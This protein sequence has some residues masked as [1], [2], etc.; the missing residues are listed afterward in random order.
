MIRFAAFL[1]LAFS[2]CITFA[3]M[4]MEMVPVGNPGND[5]D[6]TGFGRVDYAYNIGKYEVTAGQYTEFLNAVAKIDTYKLYD[7]RMRT[8]A[9]GCKIERSGSLGRYTYSVAADR[10]NRPVNFVSWGDAARFCNW[11]HNGQPTTGVQTLTT[12]EDGAY[13]LDGAN[14]EAALMAITR[15]TSATWFIPTIDEWYKAAYHKNDGVTGNYFGYPTNSDSEPSNALMTPDPGNNGNFCTERGERTI[16]SPYYMTE[17]GAFENSESPYGTFDQGGNVWEWNEAVH[18]AFSRGRRGGSFNGSYARDLQA[19]YRGRS[20]WAA[21]KY[22]TTGFR[23]AS[24][25]EPGA[26][27]LLLCG[28]TT[29][30]GVAWRKRRRPGRSGR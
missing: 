10:E 19:S 29:L 6:G 21:S 17:V 27:A 15:Q 8:S 16:G 22:N 23:V 4:V 3:E 13:A 2:T 9:R 5:P 20:G 18:S 25:P 14:D 7:D 1:A 28:A 11:L 24:I 30:L 12:T 26:T